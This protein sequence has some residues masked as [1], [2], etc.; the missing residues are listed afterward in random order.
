MPSTTTAKKSISLNGGANILE[1]GVLSFFGSKSL[2][3]LDAKLDAFIV[4][5]VSVISFNYI[6]FDE[7]VA[8]GFAKIKTKFPN[9]NV[10]Y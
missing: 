5:Q 4:N 3:I 7:I 8:K 1:D 9:T 10:K 2:E 6:E